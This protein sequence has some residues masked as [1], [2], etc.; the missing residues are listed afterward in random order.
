MNIIK[1]KVE[2]ILQHPENKRIYSPTNIEQLMECIKS[3]GLMQ[4]IIV[5]KKTQALCGYRRTQAIK[6]LGWDEVEVEVKD[7]AED[8]EPAY[9]VYSNT[10]RTKTALE[11]FYEIKIL[12]ESWAK[13]QGY[14]SDLDDSLSDEEQKSTR[15]RI[16]DTIGDK[17]ST[18][19]KI[20]KVGD[21]A[22]ELLQYI[23]IEDGLSLN[24]AYKACTLTNSAMLKMLRKLIS[25][26]SS[27]VGT[28]GVNQSE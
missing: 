21:E 27:C 26:T 3:L 19:Y 6:L 23:D 5:N 17:P 7:L 8:Q 12:K 25:M 13:P 1:I 2:D 10:H 20:E 24:E 22:H 14:R 16:A 18:V 4:R 15:E 9:M 28:A 11:K